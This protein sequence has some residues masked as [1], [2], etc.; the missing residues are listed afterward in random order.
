MPVCTKCGIQADETKFYGRVVVKGTCRSCK[1]NRVRGTEALYLKRL[2][3]QCSMR[4]RRDK[5]AGTLLQWTSFLALYTAQHGKCAVTGDVFDH[6]FP[7]TSPSPDRL[8]NDLG[9]V[10]DNVRFVTWKVNKMR[11][12]LSM[13]DFVE[14]CRRVVA[15]HSHIP[16]TS[17]HHADAKCSS[18]HGTSSSAM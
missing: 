13:D 16:R 15:Y 3:Q 7:N 18:A 1:N 2:Y 4:H 8:D 14:T 12:S 11:G 10:Q 6:R 5:H 9:Y 17:N